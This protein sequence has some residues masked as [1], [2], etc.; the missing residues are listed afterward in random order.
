[1][2]L[3][4]LSKA[5]FW[6][7]SFGAFVLSNLYLL[8]LGFGP[9]F[10][11]TMNGVGLVAEAAVALPAGELGRRWGSRNVI[12]VAEGVSALCFVG[13][14]IAWL[15]PPDGRGAWLLGSNFV[16]SLAFAAA[17]VNMTPF[18]M[19][20][21]SS[22]ERSHAFS[23][24]SAVTTSAACLGSFG[25][26]LLPA[27]VAPLLGATTQ[28]AAPYG[29]G[30]LLAGL[31]LFPAA[32]VL[33]G[34]AKR[35]PGADD[36]ACR[37]AEQ[38]ET[39]PALPLRLAIAPIAVMT[40]AVLV[41]TAG[42]GSVNVFF[43]MYLDDGLRVPTALVGTLSALGQVLGIPAA[44][45]TPLLVRAWGNGRTYVLAVAGV[46]AALV[47]RWQAAALSY[48]AIVALLA[49]AG[50]AG[51]VYQQ[52]LVPPRWRP[53]MA[54]AVSMAFTG[55]WA[56]ISFGGGFLVSGSGYRSLFL[57]GA[58]LVLAGALIFWA[59]TR[60]TTEL[61]MPASAGTTSG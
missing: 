38:V 12:V 52:S 15:L 55:G 14:A 29:L 24:F 47:P 49:A 1:V 6:L 53:A 22:E 37:P 32:L 23:I 3:L 46:A 2:R 27:A 43:N 45:L 5:L 41:R 48:T 28:E 59:Y 25:A 34:A 30:M 26:G 11:G 36:A 61:S 31:L 39:G 57:T 8:R 58:G 42:D 35:A 51:T 10:I 18:L 21:T 20:R 40:L 17:L 19:E 56:I 4:F 9:E 54:G 7:G 16:A 50:P 44:L 33:L 13:I 60:F